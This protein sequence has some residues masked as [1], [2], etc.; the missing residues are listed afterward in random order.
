MNKSILSLIILLVFLLASC[1]GPKTEQEEIITP[2]AV[3][4]TTS[5]IKG[6]IETRLVLNAKTV[7]LK[8]N[9]VIA[10]ISGYLTAVHVKFGDKVQAGDILFE[11]QTREN[12]AMQ[13]SGIGN[14]DF[15]KI[16]VA[17]TISGLVNEPVTLGTGVYVAEGTPL[18]SL[19][20]NNDLLVLVNVPF[21]NH[22][23]MKPGTPCQLFLPDNSTEK[24]TVFQVRPFVDETS[25]TQQVYI[26][27]AGACFLPENMNLTAAFRKSGSTETLLLPKKA[28]LSNETQDEFWVMKIIDDSVAVKVPVQTGIKNDTMLEIVNTELTPEDIIILEGGYGL[29]DRDL[30]TIVN[31][32]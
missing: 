6:S 2:K 1:G 7:F 24:G 12:I 26:K 23:L 8:K 17:A 5:L 9:Q 25:Q 3:V 32:P 10:P 21:E 14:T 13:Q 28:L 27:P 4:K 22:T 16:K 15:G 30:V 11:I 18:C 29:E 19:V 20:D 31:Q